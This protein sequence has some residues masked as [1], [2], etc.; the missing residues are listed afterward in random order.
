ML[1]SRGWTRVT[2]CSSIHSRPPLAS[3]RPASRRSR[4][5]FPHPEGPTRMTKAPSGISSETSL[6]AVTLPNRLTM[7]SILTLAIASLGDDE[8][9]ELD[10]DEECDG[11]EPELAGGEPSPPRVQRD[12]QQLQRQR[13]D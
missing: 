11:P 7:F 10:D 3:S 9:A 1:R 6:T 5:V 2:S 8:V 12:Q 4:V 13:N